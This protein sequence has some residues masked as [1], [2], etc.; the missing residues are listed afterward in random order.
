MCDR[1][2][3]WVIYISSLEN[4]ITWHQST[5]SWV[6]LDIWT[7]SLETMMFHSVLHFIG[8]NTVPNS[9]MLDWIGE[10]LYISWEQS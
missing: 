2:A 5:Q 10:Y 8:A 4:I 1:L 3:G 9:E 7:L 6:F